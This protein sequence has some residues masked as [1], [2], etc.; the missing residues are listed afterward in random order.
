MNFLVK[1]L[2]CQLNDE[3][4][5]PRLTHKTVS[6]PLSSDEFLSEMWIRKTEDIHCE[7]DYK[8]G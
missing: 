6:E 8:L 5:L 7:F 4:P 3:I 2:T 1:L